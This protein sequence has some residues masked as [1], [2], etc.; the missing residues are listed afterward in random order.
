M[1]KYDK[2]DMDEQKRREIAYN[3]PKDE[4]CIMTDLGFNDYIGD[5]QKN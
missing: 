1:Q 4:E 2:V 5:E 3:M